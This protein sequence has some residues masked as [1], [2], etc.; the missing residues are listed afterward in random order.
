VIPQ[1]YLTE[2]RSV[3]PWKSVAQV[4]QDLIM[5]RALVE[6][7]SQEVVA[8]HLVFRGGTALHKLHL[9]P[10]VRYSEDIDLVQIKAGTNKPFLDAVRQALDGLLGKPH[11]DVKQRG[12]TM[13]YRI[14]SEIP[15]VVKLRVKVE[16]NTREH[17]SVLPLQKHA[18]A[19]ESGWFTGKCEVPTYCLDELLG[20]KMRA[21]YQR[22][23][24]RDLFDLWYGITVSK[25]NPTVIV[26]V[27]RKYLEAEG[28]TVSQREFRDN[29]AEKLSNPSFLGDTEDL[30]RTGLGY[31]HREAHRFVDEHLMSLL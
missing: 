11:Y 23:K 14:P 8:E 16:I 12:T 27:F 24:G 18:F 13:L 21:L 19:L 29:L 30:L 7:F 3:V 22:K 5:C 15:P 4:E 17:F 6:L 20:T 1:A 26:N 25:A 10:P 31:D 28:K 9:Q 2:W